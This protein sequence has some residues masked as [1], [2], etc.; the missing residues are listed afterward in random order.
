MYCVPSIHSV[1]AALLR[2]TWVNRIPM[3]EAVCTSEIRASSEQIRN[4]NLTRLSAGNTNNETSSIGDRHSV[5]INRVFTVTVKNREGNVLMYVTVNPCRVHLPPVLSLLPG[6]PH[7]WGENTNMAMTFNMRNFQCE[8][9]NL[10]RT[11]Q[12]LKHLW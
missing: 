2:A 6:P 7:L 1:P 9:M 10:M 12:Q 4:L 8:Q 3:T 11:S 5:F